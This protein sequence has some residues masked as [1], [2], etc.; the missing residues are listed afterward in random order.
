MGRPKTKIPSENADIREK[1]CTS[2]CPD[3]EYVKPRIIE[4]SYQHWCDKHNQYEVIYDNRTRTY[5]K[6]K[7]ECSDWKLQ[8]PKA[9]EKSKP[10]DG[11]LF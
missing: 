3:C 2:I 1:T 10:E 9:K 4:H 6:Q 7:T 5:S 11:L 8:K